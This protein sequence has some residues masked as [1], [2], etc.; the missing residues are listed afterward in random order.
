MSNYRKGL[1][2]N[3]GAVEVGVMRVDRNEVELLLNIT[4]EHKVKKTKRKFHL[5]H[6]VLNVVGE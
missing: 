2:N 4:L 5:T 3:S 1:N 6:L